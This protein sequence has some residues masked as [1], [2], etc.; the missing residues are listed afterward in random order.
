MASHHCHHLP[1][2]PPIHTSTT[3]Y[4]TSPPPASVDP[5]LLQSLIS[6]LHSSLNPNPNSNSACHCNSHPNHDTQHQIRHKDR[7]FGGHKQVHNSPALEVLVSLVNRIDALESSLR[8][9]HSCLY[10]SSSVREAAA[11]AIQVHFRAYLVRRSRSLR[12]LKDL[13]FIK[14]K[15]N[16][17]KSSI[18]DQCHV[19][20]AVVSHRT[21]DLLNKVDSIQ[22]RDQMIVNGKRSLTRDLVGF[23]DY[24]DVV[25]VERHGVLTRAVKKVSVVQTQSGREKPLGLR[26]DWRGAGRDRRVVIETLRGQAEDEEEVDA[27]VVSS[28]EEEIPYVSPHVTNKK[29][30]RYGNGSLGDKLGAQVRGKKNVSFAD[31]GRNRN[32][33]SMREPNSKPNAGSNGTDDLKEILES[34]RK[35]VEGMEAGL[36]SGTRGDDEEE[37]E[38][39][40]SA[41]TSDGE[42]RR[43]GLAVENDGKT[44]HQHPIDDDDF[45]FPAT[46]NVKTDTKAELASRN[47]KIKS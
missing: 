1:Q 9:R 26:S 35:R 33:I 34:L 10:G 11:R 36:A 8:R 46:E 32:V 15:F 30:F 40:G 17:L 16:A 47:P 21:V 31:N 6:L 19:D 38:S 22:D 2:P 20:P 4:C 37:S 28:S 42:N 3:C 5:H 25:A 45:T 13:A 18:S 41:Q 43:T 12:H 44:I 24:I 14:S 39:G 29:S 7:S 27:E 23:L